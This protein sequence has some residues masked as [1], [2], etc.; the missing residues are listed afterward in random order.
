MKVHFEEEMVCAIFQ[1]SR[2]VS[3]KQGKYIDV[4]LEPQRISE[5]PEAKEWPALGSFLVDL[6]KT[7]LFR[8]TGCNSNYNQVEGGHAAPFVD[9]ALDDLRL[10]PSEEACAQMREKLLSLDGS[11][12][13]EDLI[14]ELVQSEATM[15]DGEIVPSTRVWFLGEKQQAEA[16]FPLIVA[17]LESETV[18]V[19]LGR[20]F[21]AAAQSSNGDG[22]FAPT[23]VQLNIEAVGE[24]ED[25]AYLCQSSDGYKS[26]KISLELGDIR[27]DLGESGSPPQWNV[28]LRFD[29]DEAHYQG[30]AMELPLDRGEV[31]VKKVAG[32]ARWPEELN[33]VVF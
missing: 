22:P 17:A 16:A 26:W 14:I 29:D 23:V 15:P 4:K 20:G 11:P 8:T 28:Y 1:H 25:G 9:V 5:L 2:D 7:N 10:R 19:Y 30:E 6:N 12:V 24:K 18:P 21:G 27:I 33:F 31:K 32:G 3:A 13:A